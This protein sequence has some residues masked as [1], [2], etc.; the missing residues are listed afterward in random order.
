MSHQICVT[1]LCW[2]KIKQTLLRQ[3][4][5]YLFDFPIQLNTVKI[6]YDRLIKNKFIERHNIKLRLQSHRSATTDTNTTTPA[7]LH[8]DA[9][10]FYWIIKK[11]CTFPSPV[12]SCITI[13][14]R[15]TLWKH[16]TL[17]GTYYLGLTHI[18]LLI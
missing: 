7:T 4:F 6:K 11:I 3:T 16:Q 2:E 17:P 12:L 14:M 1:V 8:T 18:L 15:N 10:K 9:I 5:Y 13:S